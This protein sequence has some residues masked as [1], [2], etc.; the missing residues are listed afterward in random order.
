[1]PASF[2]NFHPRRWSNIPCLHVCSLMAPT[3]WSE[4]SL[5]TLLVSSCQILLKQESGFLISTRHQR[6]KAPTLILAIT[7]TCVQGTVADFR[8]EKFK[9]KR[10]LT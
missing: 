1:M 5:C 4:S 9:K 2:S 8:K 7:D 10:G 3:E 6:Q